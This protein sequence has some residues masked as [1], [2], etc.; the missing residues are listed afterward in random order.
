MATGMPSATQTKVKPVGPLADIVG[1]K[2]MT[3]GQI[4]SALWEHIHDEGL[5]GISGD[6]SDYVNYNGRKYSGGQ[7]IHC[8][9]DPLMKKLCAGKAKISMVQLTIYANKHME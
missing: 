1:D 3:R 7:V 6:K 9:D 4:T 5:Q 8:G 2:M